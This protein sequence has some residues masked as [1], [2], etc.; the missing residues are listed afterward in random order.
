MCRQDFLTC[1]DC[2]PAWH[3]GQPPGRAG[4]PRL[5]SGRPTGQPAQTIWRLLIFYPLFHHKFIE[6]LLL[7]CWAVSPWVSTIPIISCCR[8]GLAIA[9]YRSKNNHKVLNN[10]DILK[11]TSITSDAFSIQQILYLVICDKWWMALLNAHAGQGWASKILIAVATPIPYPQSI[12][13]WDFLPWWNSHPW[14]GFPSMME[15]PSIPSMLSLLNYFLLPSLAS[16]A[17][18]KTMVRAAD[19]M[20]WLKVQLFLVVQA[21]QLHRFQCVCYPSEGGTLRK[22]TRQLHFSPGN[23]VEK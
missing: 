16:T 1:K 3:P 2:T 23:C 4:P 17:C 22:C 21:P 14:M 6:C 18:V 12:P 20:V 10:K 7:T 13:W 11:V 9:S 5:A 19:A 15:F 8:L